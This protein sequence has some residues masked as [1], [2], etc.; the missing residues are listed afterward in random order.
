MP[1]SGEKI[2]TNLD[3]WVVVVTVSEWY[4][5]MFQNWYYWYENLTLDMKVILIAEDDFIFKKYRNNSSLV[6]L[7]LDLSKVVFN[8]LVYQIELDELPPKI[9]G[10]GLSWRKY[11][12]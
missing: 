8:H 3:N 11:E 5:D 2:K 6:V 9:A 4:D 7:P 1:I 10:K 12:F